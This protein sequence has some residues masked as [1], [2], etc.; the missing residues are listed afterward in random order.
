M[1]AAVPRYELK[2]PTATEFREAIRRLAKDELDNVWRKACLQARVPVAGELSLEQLAAVTAALI[3]TPGAIG[4]VGRS[5]SVRLSSYRT[6]STLAGAT[7]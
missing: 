6:L 1:T 3:A 7:R 4:V 5:L 2:A